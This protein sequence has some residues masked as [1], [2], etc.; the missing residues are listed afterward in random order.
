[1]EIM[2]NLAAKSEVFGK[3]ENSVAILKNLHGN[4]L[5]NM[6]PFCLYKKMKELCVNDPYSGKTATGGIITITDSNW[7]MSFTC[8]RQPHF[9][10]QPD[11]ILVVWVYALLMDKEGNHIKNNARMYRKRSLQNYA[12]ILE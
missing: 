12:I 9:P 2:E 11:D 10:T 1:M 4:L 7:V 8:N 3:P 6:P 5:L